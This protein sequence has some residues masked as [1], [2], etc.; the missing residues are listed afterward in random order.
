VDSKKTAINEQVEAYQD[1]TAY[2]RRLID[3]QYEIINGI[4]YEMSPSPTLDHQMLV[5]QLS[6][7]IYKTCH[8]NGIVVVAPIDV[9]LSEDNILQPDV[10]FISNENAG[11]IQ[12]Q[13]IIGAPDLLI[14][15]LS[16]STS[17]KDKSIKKDVYERFGVKEF[18]IVDP[19]HLIIDQFV[20]TEEGYNTYKSFC[21][22]DTLK[23]PKL[24]C[25]SI[26]LSKLFDLIIKRNPD[27]N[28]NE[29]QSEY[30]TK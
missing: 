20:L 8:S 12:N 13:K 16:P 14:E 25:I 1:K 27:H 15:V 28:I 7:E 6:N 24:S 22:G 26:E 3:V 2:S 18:W 29:L 23:S 5:T 17:K 9:H 30:P 21:L 4:R 11:I 19:V 10:V